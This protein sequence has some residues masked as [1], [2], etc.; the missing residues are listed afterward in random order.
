MAVIF[1]HDLLHE[2]DTV[3]DGVKYIVKTEIIFRRDPDFPFP[4]L[5]FVSFIDSGVGKEKAEGD[6]EMRMT[7]NS[8]LTKVN[9]ITN[10]QW[11]Y[12]NCPI[13]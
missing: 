7:K 5:K 2:G 4:P 13:L 10:K 3:L 1:N 6:K 9:R 12:I 11:S 8:T